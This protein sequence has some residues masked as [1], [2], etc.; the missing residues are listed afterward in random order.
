MSSPLGSDAGLTSGVVEE[1]ERQQT[2]RLGFVGEQRHH[3]PGQPDRL[4]RELAPD[5]GVPRGRGVA[6][7]EDQVEDLQDTG[8][9]L[10]EELEIRHA[11]GDPGVA[12][13]ALGADEA[14][15]EGRL[16]DE[17]GAR[18]LRRRQPAQRAQG[19]RDSPVHR[20]RRM[21]AGEDEPEA[22]VGDGH[23][24]LRLRPDRGQSRL[25]LG[26]ALERPG[27]LAQPLAPAEPVDRPVPRGR[28][29]PGPRVV[30]HAPD[31]P[32]LE[33]RHERFLDGLL[34]QIEVAE[35]PDERRDRPAGLLA[36]QAADDLVGGVGG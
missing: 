7:V 35:H 14:L 34:G 1:H 5:E 28:G 2:D 31:R 12:D 3:D 26:V 10:G 17:E 29:D 21:A 16:R 19:E 8:E 20:E 24:V 15:R 9:P 22:V 27:L 25:D 36:E 13:L 4:D 6:L 18:D 23:R 30:R 32:R 11:V 33:G